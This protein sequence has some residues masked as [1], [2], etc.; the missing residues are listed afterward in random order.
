MSGPSVTA[1]LAPSIEWWTTL[2]SNHAVLRTVVA[3]AHVGGLVG[4]GGCAIAA[5]RATLMLSPRD[6]GLLPMHL[7][8]IRRAHRVV[9]CGLVLIFVSGLLLVAADLETYLVSRIFWTKMALIGALLVN[10]ALLA[11]AERLARSGGDRAWRR[12]RHAS[13]I[14]LGLWFLTTLLG[15][16]LPNVG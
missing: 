15:T 4:G 12:L 11:R 9:L 10:G 8:F 5:D 7:A 16:A 1:F 14:S 6:T 2:Y 13:L 3:F